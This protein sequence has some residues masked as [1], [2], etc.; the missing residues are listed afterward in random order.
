MSYSNTNYIVL[1]AVIE[2]MT[3][4]SIEETFRSLL[5]VPLGLNDSS[6]LYDPALFDDGAHPY[7]ERR[8]G[9]LTDGWDD[10]F[11]STDYVG[12][13]WTDGGLATTGADLARFANALVVGDRYSRLRP[14][15]SCSAS[16]S[17][18]TGAASSATASTAARSSATTASTRASRRSTGPTPRAG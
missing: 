18:A 11:V 5:A 2:E 14:A 13:V 12:E 1:G 9:E 4:R 8:N 3:G 10:G 6:W 15:A 7:L 17:A 16:A